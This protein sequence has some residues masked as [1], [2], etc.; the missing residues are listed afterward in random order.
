MARAHGVVEL[1]D[2]DANVAVGQA[3]EEVRHVAG[4]VDALDGRRELGQGAAV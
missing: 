1:H 3:G 4:L 2:E